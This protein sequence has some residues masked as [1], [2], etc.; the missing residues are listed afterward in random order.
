MCVDFWV[1]FWWLVCFGFFEV[2]VLLNIV[3]TSEL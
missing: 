1:G 2:V 3:P